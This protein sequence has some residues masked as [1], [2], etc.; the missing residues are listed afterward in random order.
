[1]VQCSY[2]CA[3]IGD[4]QCNAFEFHG[5]SEDGCRLGT[6]TLDE[7][8]NAMENKVKVFMVSGSLYLIRFD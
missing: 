1:M 2:F 6:V 4:V 7:E 8:L 3:N 5:P